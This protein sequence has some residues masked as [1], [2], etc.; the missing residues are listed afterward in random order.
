MTVAFLVFVSANVVAFTVIDTH[1]D[2]VIE[3]QDSY[4][5]TLQSGRHELRVLV[6]N[7]E[8]TTTNSEISRELHEF[9]QAY[10]EIE[11]S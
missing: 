4:C 8:K 9:L 7:L 10:P 1:H 6:A 2:E 3:W 11:C 5:K